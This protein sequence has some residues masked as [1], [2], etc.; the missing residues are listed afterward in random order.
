MCN[1]YLRDKLIYWNDVTLLNFLFGGANGQAPDDHDGGEDERDHDQNGS[2]I[3]QN[4]DQDVLSRFPKV[5][6]ARVVSDDV[7]DDPV[8]HGL[9]TA[10]INCAKCGMLLG[11]QIIA[12]PQ[13]FMLFREGRFCLRWV[14]LFLLNGEQGLVDAND[15]NAD[16]DG[17][18]NDQNA[19]QDDGA[20]DQDGGA[21]DQDGGT[22]DQNANQDGGTNDRNADQDGGAN[23]QNADQDGEINRQVPNE[24]NLGATEQN[25]IQDGDADEQGP[26]DQDAGANEQNTDPDG[27]TNEQVPN[28]QDMG[29]TEKNADQDGN[30]N[31]RGPNEQD[32]GA[33]EKNADIASLFMLIKMQKDIHFLS[34]MAAAPPP[35]THPVNSHTWGLRR[36][37]S[38]ASEYFIAGRFFMKLDELMYQNGVTLHD[39]LFEVTNVQAPNDQNGGVNGQE[40]DLAVGANADQDGGAN[41]DQDGGAD[42]QVGGANADQDGSTNVD[43]YGGIIEQNN[44][45]DGGANDKVGG[46]NDQDEDVNKQVPNEQD[47]GTNEQNGDQDEGANE[48]NDDLDGQGDE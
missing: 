6:F 10:E 32:V 25:A 35:P 15:Q 9:T 31:E 30:A 4:A 19:Y 39:A 43:Q 23:E 29:A 44:D 5:I 27:D 46:A 3:E 37:A 26:N 47:V 38:P 41:A 16:Q 14:P 22:N 34:R 1:A 12:V 21:N 48:Q 45:E 42:N 40:H 33:N 20:N 11:C 17:G 18:A 2:A 36:V 13:H 24:Q 28:E 7:T 8:I